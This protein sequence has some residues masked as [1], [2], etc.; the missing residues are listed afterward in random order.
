MFKR[1]F[2]K[3]PTD[4]KSKDEIDLH[5]KVGH[6]KI[7]SRQHAEAAQKQ[8]SLKDKM[9]TQTKLIT[10]LNTEAKKL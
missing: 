1:L 6:L 8:Q 2:T 3:K 9:A 7:V 10:Q 4:K 5:T